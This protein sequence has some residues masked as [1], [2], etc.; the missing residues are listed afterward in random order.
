MRDPA[1]NAPMPKDAV[2]SIASM[3]KAMVSVAA[4]QLLEEGRIGLTDPV[5]G[6]LP[7]LANLRP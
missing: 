2:F 1:V 7:K 5:S 6:Y 4:L 3:T